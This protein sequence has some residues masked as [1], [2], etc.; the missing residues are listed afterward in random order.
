MTTAT[1]KGT[2]ERYH[3]A[4]EAG[5]FDDQAVELLNGEL[6]LKNSSFIVPR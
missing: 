3:Q 4:V 1:Y 5:V 2:I 6:A